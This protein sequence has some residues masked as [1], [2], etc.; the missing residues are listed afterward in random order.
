MTSGTREGS[1]VVRVAPAK[2]NLTL[3]IGPR[4]PDGYHELHSVMVPLAF[5]D[6]L[7]VAPAHG[8][9]DTLHVTGDDGPPRSDDL[10]LRGIAAA[11]RTARAILGPGVPLV[12]LAARLE[13]R[14]PIA[15]GL[16]GGSSDAAAAFEAA[17]EA[18][19]VADHIAPR[20]RI[21]AAMAIGSDVPFF[22]AGG[23]ALIEGVGERLTPLRSPAGEPVGILVVTPRLAVSTAEAFAR[24]DAGGDAAPADPRSTR[25][26]SEHLAQELAAGLGVDQL[27]ARA[28]VLATANDLANATAALVPE[29]RTFRRALARHLGRP[30]GQSGSGPSLWA[31]FAGEQAAADAAATLA[32]ALEDGGLAAPGD[33]PPRI[34]ATTILVTTT[35]T[36]NLGRES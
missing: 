34:I 17:L 32:T 27:L 20:E 33:G 36:A 16:A 23:P 19:G 18:W 1:T 10:V 7:S 14:I 22:L 26:T 11:R 4:R 31:L 5:A 25:I 13:K 29:L 21:A 6:R 15:A 24:Y 30:V 9:D 3:S 12:P 35:A 8:P 28:G 2:V